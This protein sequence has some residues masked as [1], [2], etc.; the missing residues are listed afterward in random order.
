MGLQPIRRYE[1]TGAPATELGRYWSAIQLV[2][3]LFLALIVWSIVW[4]PI[5]V[6]IAVG[7]L[8]GL[9][10]RAKP[11]F[12]VELQDDGI[13]VNM[14]VARKI[15]YRDIRSAGFYVYRDRE[16]VRTVGNAFIALGRSFG[17]H[18]PPIEKFGEVDRDSV[19]LR[20]VHMLW[21]YIPFP[22]FLIPIRAP[23]LR[24][25]DAP[26]LLKELH[27]RLPHDPSGSR[28]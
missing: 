20:F 6:L 5:L 14:A 22:P 27:K 17:G 26:G 15:P 10:R 21:A 7:S 18:L 9:L 4:S 8:Y 2:V 11:G 13:L 19:E 12:Y 1:L 24:V 16:F 23:R 28:P 3:S 25:E